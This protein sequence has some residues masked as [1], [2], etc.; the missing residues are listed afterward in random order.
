MPEIVNIDAEE[1][2]D[3]RGVVTRITLDDGSSYKGVFYSE[4]GSSYSPPGMTLPTFVE[5][6]LMLVA[7]AGGAAAC[8]YGLTQPMNSMG[9]WAVVLIFGGGVVGLFAGFRAV[10]GIPFEWLISLIP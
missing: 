7:G 5:W 6:L 8:W 1:S 2:N 10:I 4:P 3:G 9:I